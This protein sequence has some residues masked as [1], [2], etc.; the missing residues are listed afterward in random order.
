MPPAVQALLG[1]GC[2]ADIS[3]QAVLSSAH[4]AVSSVAPL[5]TSAAPQPAPLGMCAA[6]PY[7]VPNANQ[8][9]QYSP[10]SP[11]SGY[12]QSHSAFHGPTLGLTG[13]TPMISQTSRPSG[14]YGPDG[15]ELEDQP[16]MPV[17]ITASRRTRGLC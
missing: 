12:V 1:R 16:S 7:S 11:V 2:P 4:P 8:C 10:A 15:M 6:T 14:K 17:P 13:P 3:L 5:E 9:M